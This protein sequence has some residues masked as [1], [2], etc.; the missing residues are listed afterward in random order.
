Y[1]WLDAVYGEQGGTNAQAVVINNYRFSNYN[2]T[3]IA[4]DGSTNTTIFSYISDTTSSQSYVYTPSQL[5]NYTF[6]FTYPGQTYG[7]NGDGL[8]TSVMDNDT[9]LASSATTTLTV[10]SNPVSSPTYG[11][12]MPTNYWVRPIYAENT[13]WY[14]TVASNWLGIGSAV[15]PSVSSGTL[16]GFGTGAM[17]QRFPGDAIGPL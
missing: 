11:N 4:P 8:T 12:L 15:N 9:Y 13:N 7:A 1:M 6:I 10:Q 3:I 16:S 5:G 17:I 14:D 2:L